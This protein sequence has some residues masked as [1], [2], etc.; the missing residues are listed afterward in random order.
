MQALFLRHEGY[1]GAVGAF[2]KG[3]EEEGN[4]KRNDDCLLKFMPGQ[5][6]VKG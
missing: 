5:T 3:A 4:G 2:L 1:L 6:H